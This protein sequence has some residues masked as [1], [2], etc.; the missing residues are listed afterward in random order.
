MHITHY[1][2]VE[3]EHL[4]RLRLSCGGYGDR[5]LVGYWGVDGK[6]FYVG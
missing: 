2:E 1:R 4:G 5:Q 3:V 6:D